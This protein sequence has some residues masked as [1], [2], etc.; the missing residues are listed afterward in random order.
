MK[1]LSIAVKAFIIFSIAFSSIANANIDKDSADQSGNRTPRKKTYKA[2]IVLNNGKSIRGTL[3]DIARDSMHLLISKSIAPISLS[4]IQTLKVRRKGAVGTGILIGVCSGVFLG[5]IIGYQTYSPPEC[6]GG[7]C[8]DFGPHFS[9]V[10]GSLLGILSGSLV[11]AV[12]GSG[13]KEITL[14]KKDDYAEL[15]PYWDLNAHD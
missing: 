14:D 11:G 15:R 1:N 8:I 7:L 2:I 3:I 13:S 4:D 5:Y 10:A 6:S 12:I 9:G